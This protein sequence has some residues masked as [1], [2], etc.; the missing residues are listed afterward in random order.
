MKPQK[1][2]AVAAALALL[3]ATSALASDWQKVDDPKELR[4]LYSNKTHRQ[5]S[6]S[7]ESTMTHYRADGKALFVQGERRIPRT[8]QIKGNDQVC[9]S[10]D[11]QGQFCVHVE[12]NKRNPD[13]IMIQQAGGNFGLVGGMVRIEDGIPQF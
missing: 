12:R 8:W 5:V 2:L 11:I 1:K 9:W 7:R 3:S 13:E 10:D 4:A 6:Y